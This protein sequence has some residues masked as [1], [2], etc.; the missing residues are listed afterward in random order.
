MKKK[1]KRNVPV[2]INSLVALVCL[3]LGF[4]INWLYVVPAVVLML[5]NWRLL[6]MKRN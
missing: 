5:I 4:F 1:S 6:G 2:V 3:I